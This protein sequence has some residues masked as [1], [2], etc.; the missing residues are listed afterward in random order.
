MLAFSLR[1]NDYE[2]AG[3]PWYDT[4]RGVSSALTSLNGLNQL[5]AE[6]RKAGYNRGERLNYFY[7][8]NGRYSL[9][10]CGNCG[11]VEGIP[12]DIPCTEIPLVLSA[13]DFFRFLNERIGEDN[14]P[15]IRTRLADGTLPVSGLSCPQCGKGWSISNCYDVI[16]FHT[17]EVFPLT[18]FVGMTLGEVKLLYSMKSDAIYRMQSDILIRHDRFIDNSPKYPN[19][20][21][22][23]EKGIVV[24]KFGWVG[25]R[26]GINNDYV[27]REGDEGFF[28]VWKY[29][30]NDCHLKSVADDPEFLGK[31]G[32]FKNLAGAAY[33]DI[34]IEKELNDA[35]IEIVKGDRTQS[36]VP[37]T[38]TGKMGTFNFRRAWSYWTVS[39]K[40]PLEVA[41]EMYKDEV[42]AKF[43]RVDGHCGCIPPEEMALPND[44]D[45]RKGLDELGLESVTYGELAEILNS[46]K[47]SAPRFVRRYHIDTMPGLKLFVRTVKEHGLV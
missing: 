23:W 43:V 44:E 27:I 41:K 24:N 19:T 34:I 25:E 28:N 8:L 11:L 10:T 31:N 5:V 12:K 40:I 45:L 16:V 37:S 35:G 14:Y 6:R 36:E 3:R 47:I 33:A 7:I 29:F 32:H 9:D 39:C 22:K 2:E 46:G 38:L 17:N 20:K 21:D 13:E 26:D 18:D 30:H 15:P 4:K 1:R 42:G